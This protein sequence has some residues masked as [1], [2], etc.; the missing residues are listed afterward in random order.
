[1]PKISIIVPC[2]NAEKYLPKCLDSLIN[3]TLKDIE[4]IAVNDGS[5]DGSLSVLKD[6][7]KKDSR[8]V[9]IDKENSGPSSCRNIG[10][11][12]ATGDFIQFVDSDDWIEPETCEVCYQKAIEHNVDM[13]SF[14]ANT[15]C[16]TKNWK[17]IYYKATEEKIVALK[18]MVS[19]LFQNPFHSWHYL[20][21]KDFLKNN[22][23]KYPENIFWCEDVIFILTCWL[24]SNQVLLLSNVFYNYVQ[25]D[26]SITHTPKHVFDIFNVINEIRK[27]ITP[28]ENQYPQLKKE[29][30]EW[31]V[32]HLNWAKKKLKSFLN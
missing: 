10:I 26:S 19:L 8:I 28:F 24:K 22:Q 15:V 27:I 13:V 29:V 12:K 20:F 11:E 17:R 5:T 1:M 7:A 23:I 9:I 25:I 32:G 6:Y 4:I 2:Y 31:S 14:N 30:F 21:K 16:E 18:D 3:Q